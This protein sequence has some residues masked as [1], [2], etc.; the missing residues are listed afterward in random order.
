MR[1]VDQILLLF[2][3]D[4]IQFAEKDKWGAVRAFVFNPED[5]S[6]LPWI[7][8]ALP[9][10]WLG[11]RKL[12][13]KPITSKHIIGAAV[14]VAVLALLGYYGPVLLQGLLAWI[15]FGGGFYISL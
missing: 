5:P 1:L 3:R 4:P 15:S 13:H 2:G 7:L 11:W 9:L 6:V 8:A 12:K 14:Q 10:L